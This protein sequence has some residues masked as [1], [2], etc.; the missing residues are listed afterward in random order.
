MDVAASGRV[1]G[2]SATLASTRPVTSAEN[3]PGSRPRQPLSMKAN[4]SAASV[5]IR[6]VR[7]AAESRGRNRIAGSTSG[8]CRPGRAKPAA[9][10]LAPGATSG[11]QSNPRRTSSTRATTFA[12]HAGSRSVKEGAEENG[13]EKKQ[14][15]HSSPCQHGLASTASGIETTR[16]QKKKSG[17]RETTQDG[18]GIYETGHSRR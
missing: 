13:Q 4:T 9:F 10:R 15:T 1:V 14:D 17:P 11:L 7:E 16:K 3:D 5:D 12:R 2:S 6:H 18:L 8:T